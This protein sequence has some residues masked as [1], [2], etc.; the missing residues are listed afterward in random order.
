MKRVCIFW[1]K[2]RRILECKLRIH[3]S[4]CQVTDWCHSRFLSHGCVVVVIGLACG[5]IRQ[6]GSKNFLGNLLPVMIADLL[7]ANLSLARMDAV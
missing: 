1:L 6:T 3:A 7:S 5:G 4:K 2:N